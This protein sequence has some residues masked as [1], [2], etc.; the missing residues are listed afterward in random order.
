MASI[1]IGYKKNDFLWNVYTDPCC[2]DDEKCSENRELSEDL[3]G[4]QIS[5]NGSDRRYNDSMDYY[6][7]RLTDLL[8]LGIGIIASSYY[9]FINYD[10]VKMPQ[11]TTIKYL[12]NIYEFK[13]LYYYFFII[14]FIY[15]I[16]TSYKEICN[17][18]TNDGL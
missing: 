16:N 13:K 5:H 4:M 1:E 11:P 18:R 3:L 14:D 7:R 6:N 17:T 9:I 2:N 12:F 10:S 8:S 15:I